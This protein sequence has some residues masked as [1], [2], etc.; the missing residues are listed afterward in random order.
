[1]QET[2]HTV[3]LLINTKDFCFLSNLEVI[4]PCLHNRDKNCLTGC[5]IRDSILLFLVMQTIARYFSYSVTS[6][7]LQLSSLPLIPICISLL[8]STLYL[9]PFLPNFSFQYL[10]LLISSQGLSSYL[11]FCYLWILLSPSKCMQ[12][13]INNTKSKSFLQPSSIHFS[14]HKIKCCILKLKSLLIT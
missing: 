4:K 6:S 12:Q 7:H 10:F 2:E 5:S 11:S 14:H 1:M 13:N 9:Q 3:S 8:L